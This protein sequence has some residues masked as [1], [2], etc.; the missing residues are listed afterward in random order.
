LDVTLL[1]FL[2]GFSLTE[3]GLGLSF[4]PPITATLAPSSVG[5]SAGWVSTI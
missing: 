1:P 4:S 5:F 2:G 3:E